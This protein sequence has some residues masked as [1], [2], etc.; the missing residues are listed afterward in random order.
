MLAEI[1]VRRIRA[2][3]WERLR[4]IRL[5]ALADAPMAFG[6]TLADEQ[7]RPDEFWRGRAAGS[8]ADRDRATFIAER[9]GIW[10]GISTCVLEAGGTGERPAWVFGMWV[11]PTVRRQGTAQALLRVLAGWAR[12]RGAD[13]LNLHVTETN[14]PAIAL[15]ERLGFHATGATE[16]LPH[17]PS[18][19]EN[20]MAC[21]LEQL[22]S[23]GEPC[24]ERSREMRV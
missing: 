19:H 6:S 18:V 24:S 14:T 20:H 22:C 3:E 7:V 11:E 13:M 9:D 5:H 4:A 15:Y 8:A 23:D 21:A 12:E 17:T 10:V 1:T 16:P 2:A